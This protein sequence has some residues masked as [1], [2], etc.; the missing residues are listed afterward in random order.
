ME[1]IFCWDFWEKRN[2]Q[3]QSI[4]YFHP[5]CLRISTHTSSNR[6]CS[7]THSGRSQFIQPI[8]FNISSWISSTLSKF[9]QIDSLWNTLFRK[10]RNKFKGVETFSKIACYLPF[11]LYFCIAVPGVPLPDIQMLVMN[12]GFLLPFCDCKNRNFPFQ[13]REILLISSD[14][15]PQLSAPHIAWSVFQIPLARFSVGYRRHPLYMRPFQILHTRLCKI[16]KSL[17]I[18]FLGKR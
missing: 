2:L 16:S 12:P 1:G 17:N 5:I 10:R 11:Y 9:Q 6:S 18:R 3:L 7:L 4:N 13:W 15:R 14:A 8:T